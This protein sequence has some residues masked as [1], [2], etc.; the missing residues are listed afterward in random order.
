MPGRSQQKKRERERAAALCQTLDAFLPTAKRKATGDGQQPAAP[1]VV[2]ANAAAAECRDDECETSELIASDSNEPEITTSPGTFIEPGNFEEPDPDVLSVPKSDNTG[3][4]DGQLSLDIGDLVSTCSTEAELSQKIQALSISDKFA[5]LRQHSKPDPQFEFPRTFIGGCKRSFNYV[6]L[7][8]HKWL[9]YSVKLNGAFCMPCLLFNGMSDSTGKVSGALVTKPFQTW[10]KKSEKFSSHEKTSY[11]ECSLQLAEQLV[12]SQCIALRGDSEQLETPGNP[13]NF[14]AL[15]KLLAVND[16]VLHQHLQSPA[17]RNVTHMSP[18]TQNELIEVMGKHIV[19]RTIVDELKAARWYAILA[20]EV[21]SHNTEHLAICARFV[22]QNN[23][24][25]EEF[26]AFIGI[27]RI[28]GAEIADAIVKFL[29]DNDVP[30]ENMRGQGYDGASNMSSDRVGVQAR[31]Q[32]AAPLATYVHCSGHC[33]NLVISKSCS[34]PDI[35]NVIDRLEHCCRFFLNSPKR[36]GILELIV[37]ENVPDSPGRKPLLDLCRTRWAERHSAYQHFYQAYT[38]IVQALELIGYHR[39]LD[40]YGDKYADWD[41]LNRTE[42]QQILASITSFTFIVSFTCVYQYLSHLA[43]IT[44][45]LQKRSL[46]IIDAHELIA[47]VTATYVGERNDVDISFNHI[48]Q[49]SVRIAEN[50]SIA[51]EMPRVTGR[52]QHR[53]NPSSF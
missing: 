6:W 31:I 9:C 2:E 12:H 11:H 4:A 5:Y 18:Q 15:L 37:T 50:V 52:Q 7:D 23:D 24:I 21:T 47:E 19:L 33:L 49:Q 36:S 14:L 51:P 35:R 22:D 53:S 25:R 28:T 29:Q 3:I 41:T 43:G 8:Q 13:G 42:A 10:Q 44:V 39:H 30:I 46:D 34:L 26:L 40:K 20:D 32:Q 38:F 48:Y 17:M 27:D 16:H 1:L 45:K